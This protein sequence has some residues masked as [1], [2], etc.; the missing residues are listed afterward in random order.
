V[1][2]E[3]QDEK[4][5]IVPDACPVLTI[6][7]D[8]NAHILGVGN[9]DPMYLGEDHPKSLDCKTFTIPAFNG[10]AQVL[11]QSGDQPSAVTVSCRSDGL[12]T[13]TLPLV[14]QQKE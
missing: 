12:K 11:V 1:T 2:I 8:G 5:R 9:G 14:V 3:I 4:G 13:A 6:Q 7:L 10:L